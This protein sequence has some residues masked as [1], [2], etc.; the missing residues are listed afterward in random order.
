MLPF[1]L[2][3]VFNLEFFF[4]NREYSHVCKCVEVPVFMKDSVFIP[5]KCLLFGYGKHGKKGSFRKC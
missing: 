4:N 1:G 5:G 2:A 3:N